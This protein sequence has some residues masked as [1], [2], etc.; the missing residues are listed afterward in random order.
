[1]DQPKIVPISSVIKENESIKTITFPWNKKTIP[2]QFFMIWIPSIDEIPM[3]VSMIED[4]KK[5]ITFKVVGDATHALYQLKKEDKIGIR[6]PYGNGFKIK[7]HYDLFIG[8]GTGIAM[9]GPA[10][11]QCLH[12]HDS[13]D[14]IL[15]AKTKDE[16]FFI[17]Q[18]EDMGARVHPTTDDGSFGYKGYA[19]NLARELIQKQKIENIYTCGPEPMM[20]SLLDLCNQHHIHLQASVERYMK[21][22]VGLCGQCC[23]GEGLRVCVEGPI[24]TGTQLQQIK[25]FGVYKRNASGKKTFFQK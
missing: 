10:V 4:D 15:G 6:G 25:D 8:G 11:K 21:C 7:G 14:I 17:K 12:E 20:K 19:S 24:F 1:M 5:S 2:G 13:V 22:A 18:L 9:M 23:I 16:L 3:S